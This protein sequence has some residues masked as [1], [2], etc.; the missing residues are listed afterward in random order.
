MAVEIKQIPLTSSALKPFVHF[1][2]DHYRGNGCYVP[3]LV[4]DEVNT[5]LPEKT[6]LSTTVR[7]WLIWPTATV[8]PWGALSAS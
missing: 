6:P 2:I 8:S 7:R 5:L 1:G 4:M 3:P